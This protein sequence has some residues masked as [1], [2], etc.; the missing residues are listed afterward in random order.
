LKYFKEICPGFFNEEN[1][2]EKDFLKIIQ[3]NWDNFENN[4][5]NTINELDVNILRLNEE[6]NIIIKIMIMK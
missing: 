4:N 2:K 1:N 3:N 5:E 6:N